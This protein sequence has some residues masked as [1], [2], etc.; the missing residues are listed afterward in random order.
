MNDF[1]QKLYDD[2]MKLVSESEKKLFFFKDH[3]IDGSHYRVFS[4]HMASYTDF[5]KPSALEC[6][7]A[8]FQMEGD[9][10]TALVSLP[11]PK[12]FNV[13]ETSTDINTLAEALVRNDRLS[14]NV[15]RQLRK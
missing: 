15:Y 5:C 12:F 1:A 11:F 14:E 7:G 6:R 3:E 8:M 13:H 2:L 10:P 4:Y 9:S